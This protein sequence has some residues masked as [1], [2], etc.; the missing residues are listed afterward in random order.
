[1]VNLQVVMLGAPTSLA[2]IMMAGLHH[3]AV[4]HVGDRSE[5]GSARVHKKVLV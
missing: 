2:G 4:I 3:A 1:M 5:V